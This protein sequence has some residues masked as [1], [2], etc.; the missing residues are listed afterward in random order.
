MPSFNELVIVGN[1]GNDPEMRYTPDGKAVTSLNV[2][3]NDP[4]LQADGTWKDNTTW[5]RVACFGKLAERVNEKVT[6]GMPVLVSGKVKLNQWQDKNN[7][8]MKASLEV[9]A[10]KVVHFGKSEKLSTPTAV[11]EDIPADGDIEPDEI[12][13]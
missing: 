9:L 13:F 3:V 1:C 12:P 4:R 6:K 2:A 8:E 11:G 5:F 7:G 10:N